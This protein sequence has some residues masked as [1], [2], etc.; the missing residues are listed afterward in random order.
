MHLHIICRQS[1]G[2]APGE[3]RE[4]V[5]NS[6]EWREHSRRKSLDYCRIC[7]ELAFLLHIS[8]SSM[9]L[10]LL[11]GGQCPAKKNPLFSLIPFG[12]EK[13][14]PFFDLKVPAL[15]Q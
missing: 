1:N 9:Y 4:N 2:A 6:P 12:G 15:L 7:E 11:F 8:D 3:W 14:K 10:F 5:E 13:L